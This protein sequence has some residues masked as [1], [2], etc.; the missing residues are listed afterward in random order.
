MVKKQKQNDLPLVK[1]QNS[2]KNNS[3]TGSRK[4]LKSKKINKKSNWIKKSRNNKWKNRRPIKRVN[5]FKK[6]KK[7][8]NWRNK[9]FK[10]PPRYY[11]RIKFL[12]WHAR[13]LKVLF[14][15]KKRLDSLSRR[16]FFFSRFRIPRG[17]RFRKHVIRNRMAGIILRSLYMGLLHLRTLKKYIGLMPSLYPLL[18]TKNVL[19]FRRK[20]SSYLRYSRRLLFLSSRRGKAQRPRNFFVPP[21]RRNSLKWYNKILKPLIWG[22]VFKKE[23]YYNRR[24]WR[25]RYPLWPRLKARVRPRKYSIF[26]TKYMHILEIKQS[27]NNVFFIIKKANK[28][29]N[30]ISPGMFKYSGSQRTA[31]FSVR[32]VGKY[33]A[34]TLADLGVNRIVLILKS[35]LSTE[36][37]AA[38][39]GLMTESFFN[40]RLKK[41]TR[42]Y[43]RAAVMMAGVS[44]NGLRPKKERRM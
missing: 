12:K 24:R 10:M 20:L 25:R 35:P 43:V 29:L 14:F 39:K 37:R 17:L 13:K 41:K 6:G 15:A 26:F 9:H 21:S 34:K 28:V 22:N 30:L 38:I 36:L 42:I 19:L 1:N 31:P 2:D 4:T 5:G 7:N 33:V 11:K 18:F 44:H 27:V 16:R 32:S 8:Q 40:P 3:I 23:F